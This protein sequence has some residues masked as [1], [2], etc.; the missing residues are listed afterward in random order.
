MGLC[1][2]TLCLDG[3]Q[4]Y[5]KPGQQFA[6]GHAAPPAKDV[7]EK[8]SDRTT[9]VDHFL[10]II[11][12]VFF[13]VNLLETLIDITESKPSV[14]PEPSNLRSS[15]AL[16]AKTSEVRK[17]A[18]LLIAE[19]LDLSNRV[20]PLYYGSRIQSL[21]RLFELAASFHVGEE[22]S[23]GAAALR[24]V[25]SLH[26]TKQRLA[27]PFLAGRQRSSSNSAFVD[28]ISLFRSFGL[29]PLSLSS[30][31]GASGGGGSTTNLSD[32]VSVKSS[33]TVNLGSSA[34]VSGLSSG[35]SLIT[36]GN[37]ATASGTTGGGGSGGT[38][39]SG[40]VG[41]S[42]TEPA[43]APRLLH[44]T[45]PRH[46]INLINIDDNSFRALVIE[47]QVLVTKDHTRW[48]VEKLLELME[49][50]LYMNSKRLEELTRSTKVMRR[51]FG[52]LHPFE[53]RYPYIKRTKASTLTITTSCR[54]STKTL[55]SRG[56]SKFS[57]GLAHVKIY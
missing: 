11:L 4:D 44:W 16:L 28:E 3:N 15:Q 12:L 52:F 43:P 37:S 32:T 49:G 19:I 41:S 55:Q 40:G 29:T 27:S 31:T 21:P 33:L 23:T 5:Q 9:L 42:N 47:T 51:V 35:L 46:R 36:G 34:S 54:E 48:N 30:T 22:R 25:D 1:F 6:S 8:S 26:R 53:G 14:D 24:E 2:C 50:T 57:Y 20:L 17:K 10:A 7:P 13:D 39:N 18:S 38:G 56:S 45:D